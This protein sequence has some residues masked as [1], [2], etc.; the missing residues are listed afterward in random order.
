M[1]S[2]SPLQ[3]VWMKPMTAREHGSG[4][5][6]PAR[7]GLGALK[8]KYSM[9]SSMQP[10]PFSPEPRSKM[11]G[12]L[13]SWLV[14]PGGFRLSLLAVDVKLHSFMGLF[15]Y[16]CLLGLRAVALPLGLFPYSSRS[17]RSLDPSAPVATCFEVLFAA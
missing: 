14:I 6:L 17:L 1:P 4:H 11:P 5:C 15:V 2:I 7:Q 13:D 10:G 12:F 8:L 3:L 9:Q 16:L